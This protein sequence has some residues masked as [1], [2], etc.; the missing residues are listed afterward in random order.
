YRIFTRSGDIRWVDE[1]TFIQ[2]DENGGIHLQGI[3]LDITEHKK[4]DEALLQMEEIRKKEIHHRIKNN[5][6]VISTL[7]YLESGNFSDRKVMEAFKD[8]QHRVKSMALVH[9][10]LYQSEDM[11]SVDFADYIKNLADYLFHSYST[12]SGKVSLRLDVENVFLGMDTAVPLGIIINELVSNAL[13]H[14]FSKG[15]NGEIC[16]QLHRNG[17]DL[18]VNVENYKNTEDQVARSEKVECN[19]FSIIH[20]DKKVEDRLTLIVRDNGK[21]FP[22]SLDF[23]N[24]DSLGLQL[25]TALVDQINGSIEL[26]TSI[27]TEFKITFRELKYKKKV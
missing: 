25:V 26:N 19:G 3:I 11:V 6:Q 21:G 22:K 23:R 10:K 14:A 13:K 12:G 18:P 16:I 20:E 8:S 7:L 27:G 15:G 17:R 1:R 5:L 2:R 24:T 9:E 4:A